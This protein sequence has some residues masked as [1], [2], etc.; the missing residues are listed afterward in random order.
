MKP[1]TAPPP[2]WSLLQL[3]GLGVLI[4]GGLA[5]VLGGLTRWPALP[6]PVVREQMQMRFATPL[7]QNQ[8]GGSTVADPTRFARPDSVGFSQAAARYRPVTPYQVAEYQPPVSWLDVGST[9]QRIGSVPS[10]PAPVQ[11][12]R[13][14]THPEIPGETQ[15][16]LLRATAPVVV[17]RGALE[18]RTRPSSSAVSALVPAPA[19]A[20][21]TGPTVI[22]V[23]AGGSGMVVFWRLSRS[24]GDPAADDAGLAFARAL[25]FAAM[26]PDSTPAL[27]AAGPLTWGEVA[28]HWTTRPAP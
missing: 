3:G 26:D 24:S 12:V 1:E 13:V 4:A 27:D 15:P 22:E 28:I 17:I 5:G 11:A 21:I 18:Q 19:G 16:E 10:I 2:A 23:A 6:I 7:Q 9:G 25:Q 8:A 20:A 14:E